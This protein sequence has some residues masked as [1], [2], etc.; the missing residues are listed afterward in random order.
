MIERLR[1]ALAGM[2]YELGGQELLDVLWLARIVGSG[3]EGTDA[4]PPTM[5][6][7]P[8]VETTSVSD[9]P[10]DDDS[11]APR[12][13]SDEGET[14]P[15]QDLRHSH[16]LFAAAGARAA[17]GGPRARTV[18]SPQPRALPEVHSL[19]RALRPLRHYRDHRHRTEVD[20]EATV[21]V[22]AESRL[23]DIIDKPAQ[24]LRHTAVLLLD[25]SPSVRV[26][27]AVVHDVRRLLERAGVFRAV[28]V[29]RFNLRGGARRVTVPRTESPVTFLLTD[30]V[31][32][33]W[34]SAS[35]GSLLT[36]WARTGPLTI[37]HLLPKRLW[38][39]TAFPAQAHLI[40]AERPFPLDSELTLFEPLGG[41]PVAR[42]AGAVPV[43]VV[44]LSPAALAAWAKLL[45]RPGR[46]HMT[47]AVLCGTDEHVA[48]PIFDETGMAGQLPAEA[49]LKQFR[50]SFSPEAYRFA[51]QLS[52]IRPLSTP[53]IQLVRT[54]TLPEASSSVVAEV[55]LGGLLE[56][57]DASEAASRQATSAVGGV[58]DDTQYDFRPGVRDLL[59]SGLSTEQSIEVVEAVGRVLEPYL[60]RMP[61]FAALLAHPDGS[62][63]LS[64]EAT[65]FAVLVS[66]VLDR[67]YGVPADAETLRHRNRPRARALGPTAE[68]AHRQPTAPPKAEAAVLTIQLSPDPLETGNYNLSE[69]HRLASTIPVRGTTVRTPGD[70]L[71]CRV[72][73]LIEQAV[74]S[75][76][77]LRRQQLTLEFVLPFELLNVPVEWWS[78]EMLPGSRVPLAVDYPVVLRSLDR[79][80]NAAWHRAWHSRWQQLKQSPHKSR[81]HWCRPYTDD[82]SGL[83]LE[84]E[85][86]GDPRVVCLILSEPPSHPS[87]IGSRELR[88]GLRT[89]VP[90]II[91]HRRDCSD[92]AFREAVSEFLQRHN[93]DN[94]TEWAANLRREALALDPDHSDSHVGLHL[95]ILLDD[96]EHMPG[97]RIELEAEQ[98]TAPS[99]QP[100]EHGEK[101]AGGLA[102][103]ESDRLT[104][105]PDITVCFDIVAGEQIRARMYGPSIEPLSI[106]EHRANLTARPT[107][108]H[109][110]SVRLRRLWKEG[111][112]AAPSH[113][114]EGRHAPGGSDYPYSTLVDLRTQPPEKLH[115]IL[116]KLALA[117][118][119]LLFDVLLRGQDPRIE[120]FRERLAGALSS[121][122]GLRVRFDS[123]LHVPWPMLCL[124]QQD[125]PQLATDS[126]PTALYRRFLAHRHQIE[127]TGEAYPPRRIHHEPPD[128]LSVSLNHDLR[129]ATQGLTQAAKVAAL[130]ASNT[131][132]VER[133]TGDELLQALADR[134]LSEHLMYFWCHGS[135]V[136]DGVRPPSLA[137]RLTDGLPIDAHA[138]RERRALFKD[139]SPFQPFIML[140]ACNTR[141][142]SEGS[143]LVSLGN[144]LIHAGAKGVL[145]PQIE[146]PQTFAAEYALQFLTRYMT[147]HQTAGEA[148]RAV[149]QHFA[150]NLHNPLGF[151]YAL[152]CGMN[153]RI[154]RAAP[155]TNA[156]ESALRTLPPF[157]ESAWP[158][159][160]D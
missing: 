86:T 13:P 35:A 155:P 76:A 154:E 48:P 25:D 96:P 146:M 128:V 98:I 92:P 60:G 145:A 6:P 12:V 159:T 99:T 70:E 138:V 73:R 37:L 52:A 140:N 84:R 160:A 71:P 40:A 19:A 9:R 121:H 134:R 147:G 93:L 62:T 68:L 132:C 45:T 113:E 38:R 126:G 22:T 97:Q 66:P 95:A 115:E 125:V 43:P 47:D 49:L 15:V 143:D 157:T 81:A 139:D 133:T 39:G 67:L 100:A 44:P 56:P 124:R 74:Q 61:D 51:V 106:V 78:K 46:R 102:G 89:G 110:A 29:H 2:G 20:I 57:L 77:Y 117:G 42:P 69:W 87:G 156:Q 107:E 36:T 130:L 85:L 137:I 148:V 153:A 90:M 82:T 135:F 112:V 4:G 131:R 149:A 83:H 104:Q 27:E 16:S 127:Q 8:G 142:P 28:Q 14:R 109:A 116:N 91:W 101:A 17:T 53:V 55:L 75:W 111:F 94:L 54:A 21:R 3:T 31:D 108:V 158:S 114:H 59:A 129:M 79:L 41:G 7:P 10:T 72:G 11:P 118:Q 24:E 144:A 80:Q 5:S 151:T 122:E 63:G 119:Q 33:R 1:N 18:R 26:W 120:Q 136:F 141:E 64:P 152:H 123:E 105:S 150:D 65:A 32:P 88:A 34:R 30:A 58:G 50:A 23:L 103:A